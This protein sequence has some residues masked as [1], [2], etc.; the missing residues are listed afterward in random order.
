MWSGKTLPST[1]IDTQDY[2]LH[3]SCAKLSKESA[4][5]KKTF[6]VLTKIFQNYRV[7]IINEVII[8][9]KSKIETYPR[10]AS[11]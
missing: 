9:S 11:L 8:F 6:N 3:E 1:I 2:S 10:R 7:N 5:L 4:T